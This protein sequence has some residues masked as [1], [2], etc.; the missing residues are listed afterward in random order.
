MQVPN[1]RECRGAWGKGK[2]A[3]GF[4]SW[5]DGQI[6]TYQQ[7]AYAEEIQDVGVFCHV[8]KQ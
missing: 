3:P 4:D 2:L 5:C 7:K 1:Y 8:E 6:E